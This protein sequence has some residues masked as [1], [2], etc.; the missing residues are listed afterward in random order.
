MR[1]EDIG[2]SGARRAE[3]RAESGERKILIHLY[4]KCLCQERR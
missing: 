3:R 1:E 2:E 4:S